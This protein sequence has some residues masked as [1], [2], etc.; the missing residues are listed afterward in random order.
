MIKVKNMYQPDIEVCPV[1]HFRLPKVMLY[2]GTI[3]CHCGKVVYTT[4]TIMCTAAPVVDTPG[5]N[6]MFSS[7][8]SLLSSL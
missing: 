5:D 2:A 7:C 8:S 1:C 3:R 6:I 4:D